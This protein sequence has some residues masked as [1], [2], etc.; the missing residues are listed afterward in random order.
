MKKLGKEKR[1]GLRQARL[2]D[3]RY[4][5]SRNSMLFHGRKSEQGLS[6]MVIRTSCCMWAPD[7]CV[8]GNILNDPFTQT[9]KKT[10]EAQSFSYDLHFWLGQNTTQDEAGTAAYKTVELDDCSSPHA[11]C[12]LILW[13]C[14]PFTPVL[15]G[16]P[17]Q[18]REVQGHESERFLS[19]FP[20]FICMQGGV[21]SGFHHVSDPLPLN[22]RK[23]YRVTLSRKTGG[24]S[25]LVVREVPA[26]ASSL[27]E[28]DTYVL[29][30]GAH[31]LQFNTKGSVGQ[32]RFK[33]AEFAHS[34]SSGRKG[35]SEVTVYGAFLPS[36]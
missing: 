21:A 15:H 3:W 1:P 5:T 29:D 34:L 36:S 9:Y 35:Q 30:K 23:L 31:I 26:V 20:R 32:E 27:V 12:F 10:P 2:S 8:H 33:A 25:N 16:K 24:H 14:S 19:Y 6:T 28:G 11:S 4:G 17:V 13:S 22:I 7:S 18:Y